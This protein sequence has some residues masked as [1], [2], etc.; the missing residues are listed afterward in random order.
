MKKLFE[1]GYNQFLNMSNNAVK[2]FANGKVTLDSVT[3]KDFQDAIK[4]F[5][6]YLKH[7]KNSDILLNNLQKLKSL[8]L[9]EIKAFLYLGF[10]SS[11]RHHIG[12]YYKETDFFNLRDLLSYL[13]SH[14]EILDK[15]DKIVKNFNEDENFIRNKIE[16]TKS[17]VKQLIKETLTNYDRDGYSFCC[18]TPYTRQYSLKDLLEANLIDN[19]LIKDDYLPNTNNFIRCLNLRDNLEEFNETDWNIIIE[20]THNG[21]YWDDFTDTKYLQIQIYKNSEFLERFFRNELTDDELDDIDYSE[22]FT[23]TDLFIVN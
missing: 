2:A 14:I 5:E 12:S 19:V 8:S 1:A 15:L 11:E 16:K 17:D 9:P 23:D 4:I 10:A 7:T 6:N 21:Y 18:V 20:E 22:L 3:V 13:V